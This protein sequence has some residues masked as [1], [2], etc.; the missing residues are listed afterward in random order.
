MMSIEVR[1][2]DHSLYME[3]VNAIIKLYFL[4]LEKKVAF[5]FE[6]QYLREYAFKRDQMKW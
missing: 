2:I 6:N 3:H 4:R 1:Y 5:L